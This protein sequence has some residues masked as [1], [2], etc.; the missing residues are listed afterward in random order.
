MAESA[1]TK[2]KVLLFSTWTSEQDRTGHTF[3]FEDHGLEEM[4]KHIILR[5]VSEMYL[6]DVS[7]RRVRG[8]ADSG[9]YVVDIESYGRGEE[10]LGGIGEIFY[11]MFRTARGTFNCKTL[12][13]EHTG[14]A[15]GEK[16]VRQ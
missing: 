6:N 7:K 4:E 16:P 5:S 3:L 11:A 14:Y 10:Y 8:Y 2:E 12:V 15:N 1:G 13:I 9:S